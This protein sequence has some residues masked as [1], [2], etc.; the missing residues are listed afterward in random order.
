V[1]R[2]QAP[3]AGRAELIGSGLESVSGWWGGGGRAGWLPDGDLGG[4]DPWTLAGLVAGAWVIE[5]AG[6][7]PSGMS[8]PGVAGAQSPL[9]WFD[10]VLVRT[11]EGGAWE[12]FDAGLAVARAGET[13]D[14][15]PGGGW[16]PRTD[17][18]LVNGSNGLRDNSVSLSRR[19]TLGA[20]RI[21]AASG[22][23]A[24][25]GLGAGGVT[26]TGRDLYGIAGAMERGA[27]RWEGSFAHR[28]SNASLV[29][30]ESQDA[31]G[32]AGSAGYRHAGDR[33][34]IAAAVDRGYDRHDSRGGPWL[35]RRRLAD[36]TAA[37]LVIE[38]AGER[39][40][41]GARGSWRET[42]VTPEA[43]VSARSRARALWGAMRWQGPVGEGELEL[44]VGAGHHSALGRTPVAPSLAWR[45]HGRPWEGRVT[46]ERLTTPVWADLAPGERPFLQDTWA[47]G[48]ELGAAVASGG[49]A[50]IG[51][52]AGH[53]VSRAV[54][55][56]IPLEAVALRSGYRV[57]PGPYDFGLLVAEARW[58]TG[59]WGAAI[60]GFI[61]AHDAS[62]LQP[63]VDPSRGGRVLAELGFKLFQGDLA[64]RPRL[65][66][67]AVGPRESE[68]TP[69][70]PLPAYVSM[71]AALELTLADATLLIDGRNLADRRA[72][73]TWVDTITGIE[74]SGPGRELRVTLI[75]RLWD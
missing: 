63:Q 52:L 67:W 70:H 55:A 18:A 37:A 46:I 54:L 30:G 27:H 50:R 9:V 58:R 60:E 21:E 66:A 13:L 41:W 7:A 15:R 22:E 6:R 29:G 12:G 57:D 75:W 49:R 24:G 59:R 25:G 56:R 64:V 44:A 5:E 62:A 42:G 68:A 23:R 34:R 28:R 69:S 73:R 32:E 31:R 38:R 48:L 40:R 45:F 11:G 14:R 74:A 4:G 20:L 43:G 51:F 65:E 26:S 33:W 10:S 17:V 35:E 36:A 8:P 2:A 53:T 19:D 71:R 3:P 47:G 72:A 39:D 1:G 16:R 61:L